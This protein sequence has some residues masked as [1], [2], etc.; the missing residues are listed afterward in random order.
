MKN[1]RKKSIKNR[2]K[3]LVIV[4]VVICLA[5][6]VIIYYLTREKKQIRVLS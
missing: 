6:G 2:I 1:P 5:Q 3:A 4:L